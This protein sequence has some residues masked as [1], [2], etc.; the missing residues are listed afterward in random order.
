MLDLEIQTGSTTQE[1]STIFTW[2]AALGLLASLIMGPVLD[3]V[4]RFFLLGFALAA[5]VVFIAAAPWMT[6]LAPLL[7]MMAPPEFF[8]SVI[9]MGVYPFGLCR[10]SAYF[11]KQLRRGFLLFCKNVYGSLSIIDRLTLFI[12]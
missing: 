6:S 3:H 9:G 10:T 7:A 5:D 2:R 4:D 12:D 11:M 1:L 8:N